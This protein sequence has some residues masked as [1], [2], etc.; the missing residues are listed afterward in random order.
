MALRAAKR[1]N[2]LLGRRRRLVVVAIEACHPNHATLVHHELRVALRTDRL[3]GFG[4]VRL[5]LVAL[6]T[7]ELQLARFTEHVHRVPTS[8]FD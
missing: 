7:G 3:V 4:F 8:L 6:V 2:R 1:G 5:E